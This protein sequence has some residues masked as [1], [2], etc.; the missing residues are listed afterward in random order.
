[1]QVSE[2]SAVC[3]GSFDPVTI[4]HVDIFERASRMFDE[5]VVCVFHNI[6]KQS[7]FTIDERRAFLEQAT[8]HLPN[9]RVDAF[10]G[11]L[12]DYMRSIG[13]HIIVRGV[14]SV[15]DLEYEENE[16]HMLHHLD[17]SVET[18]F[19]LTN[20]AYSFVSSSGIRELAAFRGDV[21]GLVPACVERAVRA[22]WSAESR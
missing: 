11:L 7:Y 14:R 4:G 19:L 10:S 22:R 3:A 2:R 8:A 15:K 18:V 21:H 5:L 13:A 12:T 9:V 20:P 17:A 6:R 16:A 1:M